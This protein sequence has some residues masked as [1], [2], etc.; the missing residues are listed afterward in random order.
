MA[1]DY[2]VASQSLKYHQLPLLSELGQE[3][4]VI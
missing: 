2:M 4:G 3:K 1:Q